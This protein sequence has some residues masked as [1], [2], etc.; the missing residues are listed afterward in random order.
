ML[1]DDDDDDDDDDHD[2]DVHGGGTL[3]SYN[4]RCMT[5][6]GNCTEI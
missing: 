2:D 3:N 6:E 1:D 5:R 4:N